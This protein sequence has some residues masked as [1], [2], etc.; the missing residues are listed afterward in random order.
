MDKFLA[1][2][3]ARAG[4][5][6]LP[7]K[8]ILELN[9]KPLI[10]YTIESAKKSKYI[11]EI[12]VTSDGDKILDIAK[13]Y[14]VKTIKRDEKLSSDSASSVDVILDVLNYFKNF[15]FLI[16]LQPTSPLRDEI[17]IDGAIELL[18]SKN[19]DGVISVCE[20]EHSPLFANKIDE[21]LA[22]DGFLKKELRESRTQDL[23]KYYRLN[24]AIYICEVERFL[25]EKNL[26]LE[27]NLFAYIMPQYKSIDIDTKLDFTIAKALMLEDLNY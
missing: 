6:R 26:F 4:S 12:V 2:I 18:L 1:I 20:C 13:S 11:D 15:K 16:L 17:D 7:N 3:P 10:A 19:G 9:N 24:G 8:N 27:T 5:K 14:G 22:M 23:P 21:N 25:S